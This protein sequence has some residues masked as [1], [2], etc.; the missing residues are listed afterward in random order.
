MALVENPAPELDDEGL[1]DDIMAQIDVGN[2]SQQETATVVQQ[3]QTN[4][5][6]QIEATSGK[7]DSKARFE[8]RKVR[9]RLL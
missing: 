2:T 4:R 1:L 8:A 7:K 3:V 6:E 9:P 5:A